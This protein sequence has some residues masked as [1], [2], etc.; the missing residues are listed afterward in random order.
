MRGDLARALFYMA[1]RYDGGEADTTALRLADAPNATASTMGMLSTLLQWHTDDPVSASERA[2]NDRICA[3]YQHNRN[4]F[5]DRPEWAA[6]VFGHGAPWCHVPM[7]PP[8]PPSTPPAPPEAACLLLTGVIDGPRAGGTPKAAELYAA[9]DVTNLSRYGLGRASN[10]GG[11]TGQ[12]F[13]FAA[14]SL[15]AGAWL[16][17]SYEQAEFE[18][19]FG[20]GLDVTLSYAA[21][22]ASAHAARGGPLRHS[23]RL[24]VRSLWPLWPPSPLSPHDRAHAPPLR[25]TRVRVC[26]RACACHPPQRHSQRQRQRRARALL[27]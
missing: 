22:S 26:M 19:Y 8:S 27:P 16:Y 25:S 4:P 20:T 21:T 10:G 15:A 14:R 18:S 12:T 23:H 17:V 1:V 11:S 5:V 13:T 2:R 6:C 3:A 24:P 7:R 9:C